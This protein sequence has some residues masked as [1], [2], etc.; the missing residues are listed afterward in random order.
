MDAGGWHFGDEDEWGLVGIGRFD[1]FI[2]REP[3]YIHQFQWFINQ[4][5]R[6]FVFIDQF[7]AGIRRFMA[8]IGGFLHLSVYL[9]LV[10]FDFRHLSILVEL[11]HQS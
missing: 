3:D 1:G 11:I 5:V 7:G 2:N 8:G 9:P 6:A 10:S 4:Q